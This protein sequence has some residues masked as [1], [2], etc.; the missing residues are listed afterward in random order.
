M[1]INGSTRLY[2]II[3]DPVEHT[4]S[5]VIH[6]TLAEGLGINM[7]YVPFH[8][9]QGQLGDAV[10]GALALNVYG[11]NV[12]V[13]Y[14]KEVIPFLADLDGQARRIG[15]VNTLVRSEDGF[16]GYNTDITGLMR[17]MESDGIAIAGRETVVL[18]AGGAGR[19]AAFLCAGQGASKVWLLNRSREKAQDVA[20]EVNRTLGIDRVTAMQLD[21]Y[22]ELIRSGERRYLV[23]Q[24]TSIGMS[25]RTDA[26]VIEDAAFY[27][28][29]QAGYDLIYTP[30]ETKFMKLVKENGGEAFNGLKMLLYQGIDA[31]ELW[32]GCSVSDD[33]ARMVYQK[34]R[35]RVGGP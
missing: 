17:A 13:P 27:Q 1:T 10:K 16:I 15:A 4:Q 9:A 29:V 6:D 2:G 22:P 35:E 34:L 19:M 21:C 32:N 11:L 18:G 20:E 8:V 24:C 30:W 3:G 26:A 33:A 25:P 12:T 7:A 14:K 23:M 28:C 5:P 31:F